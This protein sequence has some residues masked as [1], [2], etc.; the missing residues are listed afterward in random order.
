MTTKTE[1]WI[2]YCC[3]YDVLKTGPFRSP[4]E[5]SCWA[6]TQNWVD[7]GNLRIV[8]NTVDTFPVRKEAPSENC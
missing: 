3:E 8:C 5:A 1:W 7:E 2:E 6:D 4:E